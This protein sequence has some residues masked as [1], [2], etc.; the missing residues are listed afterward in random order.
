MSKT[1]A[2]FDEWYVKSSYQQFVRQENVPLYEG[3][4]LEDLATLP[5]A[6]WERRGGR[7]A[8]TRLGEQEIYNLQLVEIPPR[9]ELKPEHHMYDAMMYVIKGRGATTVWQDGEPKHTAEWEEGAL[10]AIPL[11]AWH[12]EFNSSSDEPCRVIFGSNMAQ[13]INHYHNLDFVFHNPFC[14]NDRFSNAMSDFY[15]WDGK[16]WNAALYETNFVTDVRK[17]TLEGAPERGN[18][19]S[20]MRFSMAS[21]SVGVHIQE[22]AEG[23]LCIGTQT[24]RGRARDHRR[25]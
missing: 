19:I 3:S 12:Q 10:L 2:S 16:R 14:F 11:N 18:R 6:E 24:S 25:R 9:G 4:Y 8:Y 7:A 21:S 1:A 5:L 20:H 17:F 13:V 23:T 22:V 15:G